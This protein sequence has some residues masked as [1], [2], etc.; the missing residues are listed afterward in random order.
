MGM[1]SYKSIGS[2]ACIGGLALAS[3]LTVV[4]C[5]TAEFGVEPRLPA[6]GNGSQTVAEPDESSL[7]QRYVDMER[8]RG[9]GGIV[10][11]NSV[12]LL[13][14]GEE[15]YAAML[16]A[17][18]AARHH[19]HLETYIIENDEVGHKISDA[20]IERRR[21]G[22]DV[23]VLY[24]SY[25]STGSD[26]FWRRLRDAGVDTHAFNPPKPTENS[27]IT[28]YGTRDHRKILV[29]DGKVGFTGGINFYD[30]Y[31][32]RPYDTDENGLKA[33]LPWFG[34]DSGK[35][36]WR[37]THVRIEG[38]AVA[39]LQK[40]FVTLW[41][42]EKQALD[43]SLF[44]PELQPAGREQVRISIGVGGTE[45]L[46]E[47]YF[48]YLDTFEQAE[49]R[50]WITQAY[51]VPDE[52]FLETLAQA[53]RRGVD[54]KVIVPGVTDVTS[55]V[56]ASRHLYGDLLEAG[57]EIFEFQDAVLHAKTAV[58]DSVWSIVGTSNLDYLS[59]LHNHEV[60]AVVVGGVFAKQ[61]E[62]IFLDDLERTRQITLEEW[63]DR[64]L[65]YKILGYIN[66]RFEP[67][68]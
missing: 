9:D 8:S 5:T 63:R 53:A 45:N 2:R 54:V 11:G 41:E 24:D 35:L 29:V 64:P 49:Q 46:S 18:A 43:D 51:F 33:A 3:A 50:I 52:R 36:R 7:L 4:R 14:D 55:I 17:I 48:A 57:V 67:W 68:L 22:V 56:Y 15:T 6:D 37:D 32:S 19:V 40:I 21:A 62:Q 28:E 42:K 10:P 1:W 38:P 23:R 47:T 59:F 30:A 31:A 61:M 20:L 44:F 34:S 26:G 66:S 58:A 39:G 25:G 13:I 60:D 27:A 65:G 12:A 16:E